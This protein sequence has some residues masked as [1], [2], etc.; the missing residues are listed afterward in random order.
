MAQIPR[1]KMVVRR[2]VGG[3]GGVRG[4]DSEDVGRDIQRANPC[5]LPQGRTASVEVIWQRKSAWGAPRF[6]VLLFLEEPK[7]P[8]W[9]MRATRSWT[10]PS[11]SSRTRTLLRPYGRAMPR[12]IGP[13]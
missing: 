11:T 12:G 10:T 13:P 8:K 3:S 7:G 4:E 6:G 1:Q 5:C 2:R 9:E